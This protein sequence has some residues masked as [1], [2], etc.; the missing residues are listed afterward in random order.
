MRALVALGLLLGSSLV[1]ASTR[2]ADKCDH[3]AAA[4]VDACEA[5]HPKDP[6]ARVGCKVKCGERREACSGSCK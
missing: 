5:S 6:P 3:D 2:C 1:P 4:C